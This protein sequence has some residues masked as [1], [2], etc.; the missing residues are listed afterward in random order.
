MSDALTYELHTRC[1]AL[2]GLSRVADNTLRALVPTKPL[3]S[4]APMVVHMTADRRMEELRAA[5]QSI[6]EQR[7]SNC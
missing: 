4:C 1:S 2:H 6:I 7:V 3:V 5:L